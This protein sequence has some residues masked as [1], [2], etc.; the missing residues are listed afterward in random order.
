MNLVSVVDN[1]GSEIINEYYPT[2]EHEY[3]RLFKEVDLG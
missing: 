3:G 1:S 2:S